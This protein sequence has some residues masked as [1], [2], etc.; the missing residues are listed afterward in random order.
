[1]SATSSVKAGLDGDYEVG[2]IELSV[3]IAN[4]E[5]CPVGGPCP[6]AEKHAGRAEIEYVVSAELFDAEGE[7]VWSGS[8]EGMALPGSVGEVRL[9]GDV[10]SPKKWSAESPNL[11]TLVIELQD[12]AGETIEA[13]PWDVGFRRVEIRDAQLL[14]N[15]KAIYVKG[16]NR[17]EHDPDTGHYVSM[18][19]MVRDIEI[20]K[21]HNINAVRTSH[22]PDRPEWYTLCDRYGLYLVDEAN[23]E[24]HGYGSNQIQRISNGDDFSEHYVDRARRMVERDKNHPSI[25]AFSLGN[26]AGFGANPKASRAWIKKHHPERVVMYEQALSIHSDIVCPM[27]TKPQKPGEILEALWKK[28]GQAHDIGRV[29]PR[30]GQ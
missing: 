25:I 26:E 23:V 10:P 4:G 28:Q 13:V 29:R 24:S 21:R 17:H 7:R 5:P 22:Y 9:R 14:V 30:H 3:K 6:K 27:Y 1:M 16:V 19:S 11:Y 2:A 18:E 20:M 12:G 8:S 15:G